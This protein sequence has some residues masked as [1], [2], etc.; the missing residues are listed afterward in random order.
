MD[1]ERTLQNLIQNI[2][3][4]PDPAKNPRAVLSF[5]GAREVPDWQPEL[6]WS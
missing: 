6:L 5:V 2:D 4:G 3:A 1:T